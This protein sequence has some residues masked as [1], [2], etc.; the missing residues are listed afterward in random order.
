MGVADII[1]G[2]SGGTIALIL[3]IYARLVTAISHV[4]ATF[5]GHLRSRRWRE[6]ARHVDLLFLVSLGAGIGC[7]I[8]IFA[9]VIHALMESDVARP[10]TWAAFFGMIAASALLVARLIRFAGFFDVIR[11]ACAAIVGASLAYR[12]TTLTALQGGDPSLVYLFACGMVAICAMILPGISGA[13]ILLILGVYGYVTHIIK[14][15][16]H[17]RFTA[18]SLLAIAV[19]AAGCAIGLLG[20]SKILRWLLAR[21]QSLTMAVLCGFMVGAL[22]KVWPFQTDLTP[23][24]TE[25]KDK[26]YKPDWS[27]QLGSAAW[28]AIAVMLVAFVAV[29]LVDWLARRAHK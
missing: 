25:F 29:L 15:L 28:L 16:P 24:V 4:D 17:G 26:I 3:G 6:L 11:Y 21:F 13:H 19:F 1:P 2:V 12:L 27:P 14:E 18:T 5:F 20:F 22:A 8:V 23:D 9:G 7:G 10:L